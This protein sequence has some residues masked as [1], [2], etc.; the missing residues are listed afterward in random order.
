MFKT[1]TENER[2]ETGNWKTGNF[3]PGTGNQNPRTGRNRTTPQDNGSNAEPISQLLHYIP[4]VVILRVLCRKKKTGIQITQ[5]LKLSRAGD[6]AA[7]EIA[8][9]V[10]RSTKSQRSHFLAARPTNTTKK[11][12]KFLGALPK[13]GAGTQFAQTPAR[14]SNVDCLIYRA[15]HM[16]D[17]FKGIIRRESNSDRNIL[18]VPKEMR[19]VKRRPTTEPYQA[20]TGAMVKIHYAP[21]GQ[22]FNNDPTPE[23]TRQQDRRYLGYLGLHISSCDEEIM[24]KDWEAHHNFSKTNS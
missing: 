6:P 11:F 12:S 3:D 10:R 15:S 2:L 21:S 9:N 16:W 14:L 5:L 23:G 4:Q 19:S 1:E 20:E 18:T 24:A 22:I 13:K 7:V 8:P 17:V